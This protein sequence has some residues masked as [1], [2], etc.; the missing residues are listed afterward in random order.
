MKIVNL[1]ELKYSPDRHEFIMSDEERDEYN[2]LKNDYRSQ[3][4]VSHTVGGKKCKR[5]RLIEV[6]KSL[7]EQAEKLKYFFCSLSY[8]IKNN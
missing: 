1:F 3:G 6:P 2:K 8:K 5:I 7:E 4:V